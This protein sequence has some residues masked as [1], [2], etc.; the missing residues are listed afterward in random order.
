MALKKATDAR[1]RTSGDDKRSLHQRIA[2]DLRADILAGDLAP[3]E[4]VPTTKKLHEQYDASPT[5]IQNA[6]RVLKDEGLLVGQAGRS[7][8]VRDHRLHVIRPADY[9]APAAIGQSYPWITRTE[10]SGAKAVIDLIGVAAVP[11]P[12]SVAEGMRAAPKSEAVRRTL[13]L[14]RDGEPAELAFCY[15]PLDIA[16]G[17]P[18]AE[19]KK[20]KGGTPALLAGMGFHPRHVVDRVSSRPPTSMEGEYLKLP[21]PELSVLRTFRVVYGDSGRPIEVTV[22]LKAGQLYELQYEM[23]VEA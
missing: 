16:A 19:S 3:G 23:A 21:S 5:T 6:L 14:R 1:A 22:M 17:T 11:M 13:L 12:L 7:V 15:Y 9:L 2:A 10:A 20:I 8:T 4:A 18:L